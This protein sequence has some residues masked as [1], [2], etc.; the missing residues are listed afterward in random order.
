MMATQ[1][2]EFLK[3]VSIGAF[4][5]ILYG[6]IKDIFSTPPTCPKCASI[7]PRLWITKF[8]RRK[9]YGKGACQE[10]HSIIQLK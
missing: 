8:L 7:L 3:N 4:V 1:M 2:N 10:C 9:H 5:G 6:T